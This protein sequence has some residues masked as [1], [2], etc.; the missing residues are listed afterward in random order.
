M[1][2]KAKTIAIQISKNLSID[3]NRTD[4]CCALFNALANTALFQS[5]ALENFKAWTKLCSHIYAHS[6]IPALE[7]PYFRTPS[8]VIATDVLASMK[9]KTPA[10]FL[11]LTVSMQNI[12]MIPTLPERFICR[13]SQLTFGPLVHTIRSQATNSLV[14]NFFTH[15]SS[16]GTTAKFVEQFLS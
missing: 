14:M 13:R 2:F 7:K 11:D 5:C 16:L 4:H 8:I 6:S 3:K 10:S 1:Q 9:N 15:W 12:E